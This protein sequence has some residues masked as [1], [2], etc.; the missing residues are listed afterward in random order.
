M[1]K[2]VEL[3]AFIDSASPTFQSKLQVPAGFPLGS[4]HWSQNMSSDGPSC[5]ELAVGGPDIPRTKGIFQREVSSV[6]A[7]NIGEV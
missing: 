3:Q 2:H 5:C 7:N 6:G 4:F 1:V